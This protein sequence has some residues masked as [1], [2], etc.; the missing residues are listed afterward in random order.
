MV[1]EGMMKVTQVWGIAIASFALLCAACSEQPASEDDLVGTWVLQPPLVE[2]TC[3]VGD[4]IFVFNQDESF[5]AG[6]LAGAWDDEGTWSIS[7]GKV[8]IATQSTGS[9]EGGMQISQDIRLTPYEF[10][11]SSPSELTLINDEKKLRHNLRK[12]DPDPLI[13]LER[14]AIV[15]STSEPIEPTLN[16]R[17]VPA[18]KMSSA[19]PISFGER[20]DRYPASRFNGNSAALSLTSE[21]MNFISRLTEAYAQPV[22]FAGSLVIVQFGCGT[23]CSFAYALD[24]RTGRATSFPIGGEEYQGMGIHAVAGSSLVWASW[25]TS[26]SW[27]NCV[28]QAWKFGEAGFSEVTE[29]ININCSDKDRIQS[30]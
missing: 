30:I 7:D 3:D 25:Y 10:K 26:A 24:K 12:C 13:G 9:G 5:G 18:A 19:D 21:Q 4:Y 28:A 20:Y 1:G 8:I 11:L 15:R 22:N 27:E 16:T 17:V 23:G 14:G 2:G 29:E 6:V